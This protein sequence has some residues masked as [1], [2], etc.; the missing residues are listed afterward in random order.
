MNESSET[1]GLRRLESIYRAALDLPEAE[2]AEYVKQ[3][4]G[5]DVELRTEVQELLAISTEADGFLDQPASSLGG[6]PELLAGG[7]GLS[8]GS[9][10]GYRIVR[11]VASGG[12]GTV[13][14]AEQERPRR[15][16]ALKILNFG[17]SSELASRRF[18]Q[19]SEILGALDHAGVAQIYEAGVFSSGSLQTPY[20]A[21][22][23]VDGQMLTEYVSSR[24][25]NHR[26]ML[27]LFVDVCDAVQHAHNRGIIHR[28]LKPANILVTRTGQPKVLDFGIAKAADTDLRSTTVETME[29]S[30]LGTLR[31]MSP[32][33]THGDP[34]AIDTRSDVYSLGVVLYQLVA[35]HAPYE[36]D[37]ADIGECL[38]TIREKRPPSLRGACRGS[39]GD[40]DTIVR[41]AL[42]KDPEGRYPT[43]AEFALDIRRCLDH[44]PI[45]ARPP[46]A[47]YLAHKFALRNRTLT[48][49]VILVFGVLALGAASTTV[50]LLSA[51]EEADKSRRAAACAELVK[52]FVMK[53]VVHADPAKAIRSDITVGQVLDLTAMRIEPELAGDPALREEMHTAVGRAYANLGNRRKAERHLH[54]GLKI[55]Q[56]LYADDP[57]RLAEG[58]FNVGLYHLAA[59]GEW[60]KAEECFREVLEI[61]EASIGKSSASFYKAY[62]WL[63]MILLRSGDLSEA[64]SCLNRA[65]ELAAHNELFER[66][67]HPQILY[68]YHEKLEQRG[69]HEDGIDLLRRWLPT[70]E[71]S[72]GRDAYCVGT[73]Y[74]RL[75]I[76][77]K[78]ANRLEE[79]EAAYRRALEIRRV[80]HEGRAHADIV[81]SI[82]WLA[83]VVEAQGRVEEGRTLR[84]QML[85]VQRALD[86]EGH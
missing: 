69:M 30:F 49:V 21:M 51:L 11:R 65:L 23:Y 54:R 67:D 18:H 4:C 85:R 56:S 43:V 31:Y 3:A 10:P 75:A 57:R 52:N 8:D 73:L 24:R 19:E 36:V 71:E 38:R 22:E 28:D 17:F 86:A 68:R 63:G 74:H 61:R 83:E 55:L 78:S 77:L 34:D 62:Y 59:S 25:L 42:E 82:E 81:L 35:G 12:M 41:K 45:A 47:L 50:G 13:F 15:R 60:K 37:P 40:L 1:T 70:L 32:E 9:L 53:M 2:R 20:F 5:D 58:W 48:T 7:P 66:D 76:S 44:K 64:R 84:K 46:G 16:V 6:V 80:N 33:Q 14:E 29:G 26:A 79:S 27:E 72:V 39:G